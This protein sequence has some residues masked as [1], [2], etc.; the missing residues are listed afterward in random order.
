MHSLY[1]CQ[2]WKFSSINKILNIFDL[3]DVYVMVRVQLFSL[4]KID[5]Y[6]N[7]QCWKGNIWIIL[8]IFTWYLFLWNSCF[9]NF[10]AKTF[11]T[12]YLYSLLAIFNL[13]KES[14]WLGMTFE[15]R[16]KFHDSFH[17]YKTFVRSITASG[18]LLS[19]FDF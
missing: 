14:D 18:G 11:F 5:L 9:D 6:L 19:R 17:T 13:V 8:C 7:W 3:L 16:E 12:R 4:W 1:Y 10:H 15:L 2:F